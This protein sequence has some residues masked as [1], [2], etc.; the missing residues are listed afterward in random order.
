M[1]LPKVKI[2]MGQLLVEGG[3][4]ERNLERAELMVKDAAAKG[5]DIV[6]LPECLDLC[7]THPS[8]LTEAEPIPGRWSN[9]ICRMARE[10]GIYVCCG[11][12][13]KD[14]ELIRNA[15]ILVDD[16]GQILLKYHK[17][18]ILDVAFPMYAPGQKLEVIDTKFGKIGLDIC[19][20][21]YADALDI[22]YVLGRMGARIILSPSS[23]TVDWSVREG[24]DPYGEKWFGPYHTLAKLFNLVI[25]SATSVGTIVGG[26]YEGKKSVGCSLCVGPDGL[27][28]QGTYNEFAGDLV[29][30]EF[31][32]PPLTVKGTDVGKKLKAENALAGYRK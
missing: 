3:E 1:S 12:T 23:W 9:E 17:I 27:I 5:C 4:P 25:V 32:V 19:S 24:E 13:E 2:A 31:E 20:D 28:A 18:N 22:G 8:C 6:L 16:Q 15:A 29:V 26:P 10:N 14:G 30:T 7:W 21:N 11:L